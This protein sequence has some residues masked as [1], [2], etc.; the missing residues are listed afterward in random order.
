MVVSLNRKW[1]KI[2]IIIFVILGIITPILFNACSNM[3]N[4]GNMNM[5]A[6][7]Y[8]MNVVIDEYGDMHV[9]EKIILDNYT[10]WYNTYLYRDVAYNKNNMFG[11]SKDNKS[12]LTDASLVVE[13]GRGIIYDSKLNNDDYPTH[14]SGVSYNNDRDERGQYI[15]CENSSFYCDSIF[16]YNKDGFARI[17]T[18]TY[19][20]VLKGVITQYNDISELNW[21]L[22]DYQ[23]FDVNDITINITLPEGNYNIKD[24]KTYFHGTSVA[25]R[26]FV[27]NNKIVITSSDMLNGEKIEV[28]LLLDNSVF[29]KVRDINKVNINA[30]DDIVEFEKE[31][32]REAN[33]K[34]NIGHIGVIC[35][36]VLSV[37]LLLFMA[38]RFYKK[39][40]KEYKSDFYNEYYRELPGDYPPAVM[41]YLYKFRE[42]NDDDLTA[43]LLDLIR[44]K[45]LI[46]D[47]KG[48]SG[49]ND[50]D[51]DYSIILNKEKSQ[52]DLTES[53]KFLIQWFVKEIGDGEKVSVLQL[54]SFCDTYTGARQ[55]QESSAHWYKLVKREAKKYN[56]FEKDIKKH[57]S[58]YAVFAMLL[59]VVTVASLAFM[60][61]LG[62]NDLGHR[63]IFSFIFLFFGY[64]AYVIS[65]DK[66]SK[67][68]NEDFVRWRAFAKFLEDF[69]S[70][71]D[72]PVPSIIIWEHYLVYA[73][74]FGIADKVSEQLKLKFNLEEISSKDT[75]FVVYFGM[76]YR[77]NRFN[78]TINGMR[79]S[80]S[81][82]ITRYHASQRSSS[83]FGGRSGGG[84]SGGSSFGGGGGSF[85]GGRR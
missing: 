34:Y 82:T 64:V 3:G 35:V 12:S 61:I 80:A 33:F 70:F 26:K 20:Y 25:K 81:S 79:R 15:R 65:A 28:R 48:S 50:E 17:T 19:S 36:Y 37:G 76:G 84:F 42:I 57:R 30:Y 22:L 41:G 45:Y 27:D 46:L 44:R 47:A 58:K 38:F 85:R 5:E 62:E 53:E 63:L 31:Q 77:I 52:K 78:S 60:A 66:R 7:K 43:T 54:N 1:N 49:V 55:Y 67:S 8:T 73:T 9:E 40:D 14:F 10:D 32:I 83:S 56:F 18:F 16:Y 71:E 24:E 39:Y 2:V 13:D 23:Y 11:N 74:S 69:S 72:Y 4:K 75:T 68:G 51:P 21:V 29:N 59:C 6:Q